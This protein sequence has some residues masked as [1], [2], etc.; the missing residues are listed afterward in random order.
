MKFSPCR[1]GDNCTQG[2][3]HC[4]GCDRSHEEIAQTKQL[5]AALS[6]FAEKMGYENYE[7]FTTFVRDKANKKI[8]LMREEDA[9]LGVGLP[10]GR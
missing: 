5:V 10:F 7:E 6:Q 8:Q 1:G 4:Q 3:T 2:G 9:A